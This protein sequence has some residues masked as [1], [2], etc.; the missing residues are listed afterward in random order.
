MKDTNQ[1]NMSEQQKY[2]YANIFPRN[3]L[4]DML[5]NRLNNSKSD[6]EREVIETTLKF[7]KSAPKN[8]KR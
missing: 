6:K 3:K 4:I 2:F 1:Y 5:V 7:L 8:V